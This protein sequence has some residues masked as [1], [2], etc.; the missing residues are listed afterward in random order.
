MKKTILL[1]AACILT[2]VC[3]AQTIVHSRL[4]TAVKANDGSLTITN[5]DKRQ[6]FTG[7]ASTHEPDINSPKSANIHPNGKKYYINSLEGCATVVFEMGTNRKLKTI[8]HKCDP[9]KD[10]LWSKPSELYPFTHYTENL[11]TFGGK[12]VEGCFSHNG[13]YFWVPYYRRTF[14]INAQDPSALAVIDTE[15]DEIVLLMET[16]PLPKMITASHDG[17]YVAVT[18]WGNNTVGLIRVDSD[19]PRDWHHERLL[20]VDYVLPLNFSMKTHVDRDSDSGYCLR[21]TVFTPD[22]KYL[23]VGCMGNSGGIAV[24][25]M[26]NMEYLGRLQGMRANVRHLVIKN[27]YLYLSINKA[28]YVQRLPLEKFLDAARHINGKVGTVG[29]W[30]EC[31]VG[32]G[33]RTIEISPSGNYVFAACNLASEVWV[34]DTRNMQAIAH[35]PCDSYPV[36]LDISRDGKWIIVTSQGRKNGGGNAVNIY[37][38]DYSTTEPNMNDSVKPLAYQVE[39]TDSANAAV[40]MAGNSTPDISTVV[41]SLWLWGSTAAVALLGTIFLVRRKT[42]KSS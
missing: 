7:D 15:T 25:D 41:S 24:F 39:Q 19:N 26:Q 11:N 27:G 5:V 33:A 40:G 20:V 35:I 29:G 16:G 42:S 28:G 18:H 38:V 21:G 37:K 13:R 30:E 17:K 34:V 6:N 8:H 1:I 3:P 9:S 10:A 2:T 12:P 36:G 14:D 31:K 4:G 23:L 22:D 32:D